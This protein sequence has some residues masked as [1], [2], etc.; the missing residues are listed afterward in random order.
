MFT[1]VTFSTWMGQK[2]K[3]ANLKPF[4]LSLYA[5]AFVAHL[6]SCD[7]WPISEEIIDFYVLLDSSLSFS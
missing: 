4:S 5:F 1:L 6:T 2:L 7:V 3:I